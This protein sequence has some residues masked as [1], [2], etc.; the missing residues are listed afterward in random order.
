[1]SSD[2]EDN[3]LDESTPTSNLI[4]QK[5]RGISGVVTGYSAVYSMFKV[6][7]YRSTA[8]KQ[9]AKTE[10]I[11]VLHLVDDVKEE[12]EEQVEQGLNTPG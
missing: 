11:K 9:A 3:T 10:K 5:D 8:R 4:G 12:E 6:K 2:A 7:Y 1:V